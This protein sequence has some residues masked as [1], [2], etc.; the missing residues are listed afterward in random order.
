MAFIVLLGLVSKLMKENDRHEQLAAI[1]R[2][3]AL[4]RVDMAWRSTD[5]DPFFGPLS[6]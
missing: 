2:V 6:G 3:P 5:D 4:S 1:G